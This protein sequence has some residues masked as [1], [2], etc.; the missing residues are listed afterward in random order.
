LGATAHS[1]DI[2][3]GPGAG[4]PGSFAKEAPEGIGIYR[5]RVGLESWV[6]GGLI[7]RREALWV[8]RHL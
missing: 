6:E 4:G 8:P 3:R 5:T 7:A 2:G 1:G